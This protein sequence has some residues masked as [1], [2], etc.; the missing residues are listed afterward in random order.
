VAVAREA[1]ALIRAGLVAVVLDADGGGHTP[2][3]PATAGRSS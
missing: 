2:L 1:R 3:V